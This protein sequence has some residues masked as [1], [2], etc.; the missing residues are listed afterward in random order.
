MVVRSFGVDATKIRKS[1][2]AEFAAK[3]KAKAVKP[4][5]AKKPAAKKKAGRK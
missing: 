5:P 3:A 1:L 2:T 4:K